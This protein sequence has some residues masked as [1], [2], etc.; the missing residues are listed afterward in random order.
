MHK[1]EPFGISSGLRRRQICL[2]ARKLQ[3]GPASP[4]LIH[5]LTNYRWYRNGS[6]RYRNGIGCEHLINI[7]PFG[8]FVQ[9]GTVLR[10]ST[11]RVQCSLVKSPSNEKY[12]IWWTNQCAKVSQLSVR[13]KEHNVA[14]WLP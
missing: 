6:K 11:T 13:C 8:I 5:P 4:V 12:L 1:T 2:R 7:Q 9:L 10:A 3:T 14:L